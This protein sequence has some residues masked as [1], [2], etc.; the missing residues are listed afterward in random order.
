[1]GS[2]RIC[3]A[4]GAASGGRTVEAAASCQGTSIANRA[5]RRATLF[6][7]SRSFHITSGHVSETAHLSRA[8]ET[9]RQ[10]TGVSFARAPGG[11]SASLCAGITSLSCCAGITSLSCRAVPARRHVPPVACRLSPVL[12]CGGIEGIAQP[13]AN[14]RQAEH[15]EREQQHREEFQMPVVGGVRQ[16]FGDHAAPARRR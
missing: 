9:G 14:E 15:G 6:F 4:S 13:I 12:L 3:W 11:R 1:P 10:A 16:T 2:R 5:R 8:P 7:T